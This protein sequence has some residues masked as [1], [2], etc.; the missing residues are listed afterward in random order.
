MIGYR[1]EY[2]WVGW[3]VFPQICSRGPGSFTPDSRRPLLSLCIGALFATCNSQLRCLT[4]LCLSC[5]PSHPC[6]SLLPP[7]TPQFF[8][9]FFLLQKIAVI[10]KK[11]SYQSRVVIY[12]L[13]V[14]KFNSA[15]HTSIQSIYPFIHSFIQEVCKSASLLRPDKR[16][17]VDQLLSGPFNFAYLSQTSSR[18]LLIRRSP[19]LTTHLCGNCHHVQSA[20][21]FRWQGVSPQ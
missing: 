13:I 2:G 19:S 17:R 1:F 8:S 10:L 7:L 11:L 4:F 20:P 12:V 18:L 16:S 9:G 21:F 15:I 5:F 3:P 14:T 6:L